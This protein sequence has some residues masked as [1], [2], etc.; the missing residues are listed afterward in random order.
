MRYKDRLEAGDAL[1]KELEKYKGR[2]DVVVLALPRGGVPLGYEV[3]R[4]LD[5]PLDVFVVRKLGLPGQEEFA[6]GALA[7]GGVVLLN[8]ALAERAG[9]NQ[10]DVMG[11]VEREKEE[12]ERRETAY[13]QD[14][15]ELDLQGR[16]VIVVDDGLATGSTTKAA[17]QAIERLGPEKVVA[18]VPVAPPET[19]AEIEE[20][21]HETVCLHTPPDFRAVGLWYEDFSQTPDEEV[22]FFL[23]KAHE[24]LG[25]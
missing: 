25:T 12:L 14:R 2:D 6:M 23:N 11:V 15:G 1:A 20:L 5:A 9:V 8:R 17:L 19:C 3:A 16:T 22:A 7:S 4:A 13:R 10:A 21:A 24:E 18:A